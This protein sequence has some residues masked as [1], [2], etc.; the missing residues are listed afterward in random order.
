MVTPI[1]FLK[2]TY[3]ELQQV[4]WPTRNEIIRL[5]V[6]VIFISFALGLY[7]GGIDFILTKIMSALL[8]K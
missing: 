4:K 1:T 6:M 8:L 2:Q 7:I 3:D 5:T